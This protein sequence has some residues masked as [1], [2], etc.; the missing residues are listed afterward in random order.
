MQFSFYVGIDVSKNSLDFAV[1]DAREVVF[2]IQV[3]NN[4]LGLQQF[5]DQ[6]QSEEG[7]LSE[8]LLCC[9]HT[10][11]Y[12]QVLLSFATQCDISL[13]RPLRGTTAK[14]CTLHLGT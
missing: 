14:E 11:V 6:Y 1:R 13:W 5:E 9:E 7:R 3:D 2:H 4:G 12:S 8:S 10:G